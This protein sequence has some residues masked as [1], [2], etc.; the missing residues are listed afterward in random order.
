MLVLTEA[1]AEVAK[2]IRPDCAT[3]AEAEIIKNNR[4]AGSW[5]SRLPFTSS[6][7]KKVQWKQT[8]NNR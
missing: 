5:L 2:P 3:R 8:L 4:N 7:C 6:D 1:E